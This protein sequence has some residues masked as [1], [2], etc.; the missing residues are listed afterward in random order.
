MTVANSFQS[1]EKPST[2]AREDIGEMT[3]GPT[4]RLGWSVG[5]G[6]FPAL[7]FMGSFVAFLEGSGE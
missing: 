6:R 3:S 1:A 4:S 7:L 5:I 2:S